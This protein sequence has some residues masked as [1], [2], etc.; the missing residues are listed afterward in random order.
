MDV[1]GVVDVVGAAVVASRLPQ[2]HSYERR[3]LLRQVAL[4]PIVTRKRPKLVAQ[5][6]P[7]VNGD[8]AREE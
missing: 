3:A 7:P 1:V 2:R 4:P 8:D 6:S 5:H